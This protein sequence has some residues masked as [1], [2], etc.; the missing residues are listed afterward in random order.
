MMASMDFASLRSIVAATDLVDVEACRRELVHV[1][2]VRGLL[3]A[4]EVEVLARLDELTVDAP[5]IFPEDELAK[6]AKSSL[7][8]AVKVRNRK[9]TCSRVPE[10]AA[11]LAEGATTG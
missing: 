9:E 3:D 6:A 11:A 1:R 4:R 2:G 7:N 10:L 8:K 5:A